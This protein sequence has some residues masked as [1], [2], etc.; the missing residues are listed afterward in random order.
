M[1]TDQLLTFGPY[2]LDMGTGQLKRGK[3]EVRLTGKAAALLRVL[4]ERA[5]QVVSKEELFATVWSETV[6]SDNA[7]TSCIKELR[8][9][10]RDNAKS[11]RYIETIHRRGFQFIAPVTAAAVAAPSAM[12]QE[13]STKAASP[14]QPSPL[15]TSFVGRESELARLQQWVEKAL[16][17]QRQLVFVTGEPGIGK[18]TLVEMFLGQVAG[19]EKLWI[20]RGQCVEHYGTGEA[21]LPVL[22]ALGRLCRKAEGQDMIAL[23]RHEAPTWLAQMPALVSPAELEEL[24]RRT[25]GVTRERMLRE[26]AEALEA[27]TAERTLILWLE[28]LHWSDYSTLDL[29]SVLA[30]RQERARLL[31]LG[32]YRPVEV[33]TRDHPLKGVKHELQ[34]H[35]QCEELA[36]DFLSEASVADY[37]AAR[38][39]GGTQRGALLQR[40]AHLI[41]QRTDGNALFMVNVA[42]E[43]AVRGVMT[44]EEHGERHGN[45]DALS[46]EAP[47]NLRQMIEQQISRVTADERHVLEAASVVGADF[48]AAAVAAGVEQTAEGVEAQC[49]G[50]VRRGQFLVARGTSEWPDGTVA[51]RYGFAHALYQ[52]V[53]YEQ[54]SASRR[55]RLHRQIG[56][57]VE[58]G[59]GEH[60]REMAAELAM[61]FEQGR[62]YERA[63]QYLQ[64]AGENA[65]RRSAN[66]EAISLLTK[67][68]DLLTLLPDTPERARQ[69]LLL[70]TALTVPLVMT[71]G[72]AAPEVEK[73]YTRARAL[74]QQ[75]EEPPPALPRTDWHVAVCHTTTG[76]SGR[77][78][79]G[80]TVCESG[81]KSLRPGFRADGP[82]DV[83]GHLVIPGRVCPSPSETRAGRGPL[84]SSAIS[85]S[86]VSV[87]GG[88]RDTEPGLFSLG[89]VVLRVS[90]SSWGI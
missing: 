66:R 31:I 36:L 7:L 9:A 21:Y 29:L 57:R 23:L 11:P 60:V 17:G 3:Q 27:L 13:P 8:Q 28:D 68:L 45:L 15:I 24:Q 74:C 80:G 89:L 47:A 6:V 63:V 2:Q 67:G 19:E 79:V 72:Y 76:F 51:G 52:E 78:G 1:P 87:R 30:R 81:A 20:G 59:Y 82:Y 41:H 10:L 86:D 22:E 65:I 53:V 56:E 62:D 54:L 77:A 35:G 70:Q 85:L 40:V 34:L 4:V 71:Q 42:N 43:L 55:V 46:I 5:G 38:F 48:S 25:A 64:Q 39:S 75:V 26:L 32:T 84:Q 14:S 16:D 88:P 73:V 49:E 12:V 18:T 83:G 50:L 61:H 37:L 69:K 90:R 58:Q 44:Q 33:L